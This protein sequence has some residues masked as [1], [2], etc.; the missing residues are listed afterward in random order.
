[1]TVLVLKTAALI[2]VS[3]IVLVTA[4]LILPFTVS[5]RY[6]NKKTEIFVHLTVLKIRV[7]PVKQKKKKEKKKAE[8]DSSKEP[9]EKEERQKKFSLDKDTVINLLPDLKK[10]L[11][12]AGSAV[13][14]RGVFLRA[15]VH[16]DDPMQTG[17]AAGR[18]WTAI[19]GIK[20]LIESLV[21]VRYKSVR[22]VPDFMSE[23]EGTGEFVCKVTVI[24]IILIVAFLKLLLAYMKTVKGKTT[25]VTTNIK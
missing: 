22:V 6:A 12:Q 11:K 7:F 9:D 8:K 5:V 4:V 21:T 1:M 14:L 24:P 20:I 13:K 16:K 18:L 25:V 3:L 2:I 10:F 15:I 19:N 17:L 23:Y